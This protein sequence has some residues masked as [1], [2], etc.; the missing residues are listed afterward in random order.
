MISDEAAALY[1]ND[2]TA[3]AFG[4]ELVAAD[5]TSATVRMAVRPD[6]CNGF[7]IAHGGMVFLLADSAM[8]F[9]SNSQPE[10]AVATTAEIDW[11]APVRAGQVL[12]ATATRRWASKRSCLWDVEITADDNTP[13]A[14]FRGRT[15]ITG[16]SAGSQSP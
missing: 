2:P 1:S 12:S 3:P 15:R 9:A 6:M 8:A 16:N 14:L 7:G 13:V 5:P 10:P 4:I 11:L